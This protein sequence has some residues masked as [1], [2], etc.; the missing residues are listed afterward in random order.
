MEDTPVLPLNR[1]LI[2]TE[3]YFQKDLYAKTML[4][5]DHGAYRANPVSI[6]GPANRFSAEAWRKMSAYRNGLESRISALTGWLK[7][8]SDVSKCHSWIDVSYAPIYDAEEGQTQEDIEQQIVDCT[9]TSALFDPFLDT[10]VDI[11]GQA[12]ETNDLLFRCANMVR[13]LQSLK[14]GAL[15]ACVCRDY[16]KRYGI[17]PATLSDAV[18]EAA[19]V[20]LMDPCCNKK[21]VYR[22]EQDGFVLYG[23]G[24]NGIDEEGQYEMMGDVNAAWKTRNLRKIKAARA[25]KHDDLMIW[26]PRQEKSKIDINFLLQ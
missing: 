14:R 21:Y 8:S 17:W 3:V 2:D 7:S 25:L 26:P 9:K 23:M 15:L 6:I 11:R 20:E 1:C 12:I 10:R 18:S 16:K 13:S 22:P 4:V 24:V 19:M 5:N